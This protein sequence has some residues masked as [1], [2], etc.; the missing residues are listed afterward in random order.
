MQLTHT[1]EYESATLDIKG[2]ADRFSVTAKDASRVYAIGL[3]GRNHREIGS[4]PG[5]GPMLSPDGK[6]LVYMAGTWTATRLMVSG[7][8]GSGVKQIMTVPRSPGTITGRLTGAYCIH[9]KERIG[10][11]LA[12]FCDN[13]DG[14]ERR[15]VT[16]IKPEEGNAQWPVW[17]RNGRQ[18][19]IQV[20]NLKLHSGHIWS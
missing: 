20:S 10:R 12:V 14:S 1:P 19:A 4:V 8:D 5:R 3:D 15:Q 13:A 18:L 9:G 6:R 7:L 17:S 16:H 11:R 2:E